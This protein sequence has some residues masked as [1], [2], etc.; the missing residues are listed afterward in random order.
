[1]G[2]ALGEVQDVKEYVAELEVSPMGR[3]SLLEGLRIYSQSSDHLELT[4]REL[5]RTST[6]FLG[7]MSL[8]SSAYSKWSIARLSVKSLTYITKRIGP[9]TEPWGTPLAASATC[10]RDLLTLSW[11]ARHQR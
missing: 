3:C 5:W 1:M 4:T 8:T 10:D 7:S 11:K 9:N 6:R 2:C